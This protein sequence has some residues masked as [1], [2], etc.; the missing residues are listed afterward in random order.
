[1]MNAMPD[2]DDA[3]GSPNSEAESS[4]SMQ[5]RE[6]PCGVRYIRRV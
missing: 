3:E 1:M 2:W 4:S 6:V 5:Q